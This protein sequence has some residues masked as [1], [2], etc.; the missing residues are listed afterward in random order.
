MVDDIPQNV[1]LLADLLGVKGYAVTTAANGEEALAKVA[2]EPPDLV[3]LDVMMPGMSGYD[4]CRRLRADPATALLP[5]V[6]CTSLDPQQERINGIAAGADDFLGKP[7]NQPELFARVQ[8]LLRI[9]RLHDETQRQAAQLADWSATLERRVAEQV[10]EN[11]RL[12]RLKRFFSPKLAE[13]IVDGSGEDPLKSRRREIVVVYCDLR[14]FT[15][16]AET[17]EPE[18]LMRTLGS[19]HAAMGR[20]VLAHEATLERFTGDGMMVFL[21]DP[22]PDRQCGARRACASR[23]RCARPRS[24]L[25][26]KWKKRGVDLGLGI[27][28]AQGFATVGAIGF[29][30]R[31]DYGAIGTVTNLAARLCQHA[32]AGEIIVSQRV[33]CGGERQRSRPRT[34]ASSRCTASRGRCMRFAASGPGG[35]TSVGARPARAHPAAVLP[36]ASPAEQLMPALLKAVRKLVRRRFRRVLLGRCRRRHDVAVRGEAVAGAGARSSTSSATT[37]PTTPRSSAPSRRARGR[38]SRCWRFPPRATSS[39]RRTTTT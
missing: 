39:G 8:S 9:K 30:G 29:E 1:K 37:M 32:K 18:E 27:G 10:A 33:L 38:P 2:A 26:A 15:A 23:W 28:V 3:L 11:E 7:I 6:L 35:M 24:E 20:L 4:V 14:G 12:S 36:R 22:V 21:G 31:I 16:F 5:V 17:T 34:W 19:F 25:S 13:M